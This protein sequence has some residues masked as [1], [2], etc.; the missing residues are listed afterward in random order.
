MNAQAAI[1][2][3][4]QRLPRLI[5]LAMLTVALGGS[6]GG[7][8]CFECI[9][10]CTAPIKIIPPH[11]ALEPR[12]PPCSYVEP[13]CYGYHS[14]CWRSWPADC[15]SARDCLDWYQQDP[16]P[17]P[18]KGEAVPPVAPIPMLEQPP[19]PTP[20]PAPSQSRREPSAVEPIVQVVEPIVEAIE[21]AD[22]EENLAPIIRATDLP[23]SARLE[24]KM[25]QSQHS[26][27]RSIDEQ[28]SDE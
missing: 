18:D 10:H 23:V 22:V 14:T 19:A 27:R 6:Q 13:L 12:N 5:A 2:A 17:I 16:I 1:H 11:S 15:D 20:A 3:V 26:S 4:C 24:A 25:I 7:C 9:E 8:C 28:A 21:P